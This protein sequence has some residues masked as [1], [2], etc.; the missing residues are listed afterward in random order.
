MGINTE[1]FQ[2]HQP[3]S[4][5]FLVKAADN[6][7]IELLEEFGIPTQPIIFRGSEESDNVAQSFVF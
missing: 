3:M 7:P 4:Y 2:D 6:V 5:G 1:A